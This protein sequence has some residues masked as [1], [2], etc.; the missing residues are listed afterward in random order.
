MDCTV[1]GIAPVLHVGSA[2]TSLQN[3]DLYDDAL[4]DEVDVDETDWK[5]E[6]K[7]NH[8]AVDQA[9]MNDDGEGYVGSSAIARQSYKKR[10]ISESISL[11]PAF[12]IGETPRGTPN[13]FMV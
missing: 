11:L 10:R 4:L 9:D 8:S 1:T 13:R 12:Q 2:D 7:R 6:R 5:Q 3:L